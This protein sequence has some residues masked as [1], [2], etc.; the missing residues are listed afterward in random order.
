MYDY[1]TI[2]GKLARQALAS[3]P[4]QV[5]D[6]ARP[7]HGCWIAGH[8]GMGSAD[9][10]SHGRSLATAGYAL[11]AEGSVLE[12][13]E[14]LLERVLAGVAFVGRWQRETGLIDLPKVDFDSPPDTAFLVQ[15]LCPLLELAR[16]RAN[17]GYEPA[18]RVAEA[19]SPVLLRGAEGIVDR[20]FRTPN[21]RWVVCSALAQAMSLF[22]GLKAQAYVD[23]ILAETIDINSDG[24]FSERSSSVYNAVCCRALRLMAEHLQ[25]PELIEHVRANLQLTL[26]LLHADGSVLTTASRRQD[27]GVL[28]PP[29]RMADSCFDLAMRDGD[30]RLATL[31][32]Q[33]AAHAGPADPW[34]L[35]PLLSHPHYRDKRVSREPLPDRYERTFEQSGLWRVRDGKLSA[36]AAKGQDVPF[37]L[38]YGQLEMAVSVRGNY[39][40]LARFKADRMAPGPRGVQ[41]A[42]SGRERQTPGWDLPLGEPVTFENPHEGYYTLAQTGVRG[43]W[44]LPELDITLDITRVTD[45]FDLRVQT[46]GGVDRIPFVIELDFA[47]GDGWEAAGLALPAEAGRHVVLKQG[48][49]VLHGG[50]DAV[51]VGPGADAHRC[52]VEGATRPKGAGFLVL[53]PLVSPVDHTLRIRHGAWSEADRDLRYAT[54]A[55]TT[56]AQQRETVDVR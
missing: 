7:E 55:M 9:H 12:N 4:H 56:P 52:F 25:R 27:A 14:E 41:M 37:T 42:H 34:L 18:G 33:L 44:P 31:A 47:G 2:L 48:N 22:P 35:Q 50:P 10:T 1:D 13:D 17:E 16:R 40:D 21:H 30:G 36:T 19:L 53:I 5:L 32:D 28:T 6:A 11:L 8:Y 23:S 26:Y 29:V 51:R 39:F 20:G 15:L 45:G 54:T 43:R 3:Y 49:G 24:D 46:V 38:R